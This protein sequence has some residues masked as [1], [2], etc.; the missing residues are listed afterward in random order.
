MEERL[1]D[2]L[3][4]SFENST[5]HTNVLTGEKKIEQQTELLPKEDKAHKS[6]VFY[7]N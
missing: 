3:M 6:Y 7:F 2:S 4:S 1:V 5:Q